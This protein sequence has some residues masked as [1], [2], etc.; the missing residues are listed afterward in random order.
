MV[1]GM[2]QLIFFLFFTGVIFCSKAK[3]YFV[4]PT[5]RI[6]VAENQFDNRAALVYDKDK[7]VFEQLQGTPN[8][9]WLK[10]VD[11][12]QRRKKM[13]STALAFPL[14]FGIIGLH[15]IYLGSKPYIPLVYIATLGGAIGILPLID[16]VVLLLDK[17][18]SPYQNN[19][20][21]FM[22]IK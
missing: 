3:N 21:V 4:I 11:K 6:A 9:L 1:C 5:V 17:D 10:I 13:I 12:L 22:W 2:K 16:F 7:L 8:V 14:P 19:P 18:I 15:R 20:Q